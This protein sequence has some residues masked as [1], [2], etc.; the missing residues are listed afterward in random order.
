MKE[1][2]CREAIN[3]FTEK[4]IFITIEFA[5]YGYF[6]YQNNAKKGEEFYANVW[7]QI[8]SKL[9]FKKVGANFEFYLSYDGIEYMKRLQN[10]FVI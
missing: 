7:R 4:K 9:Y 2:T 1:F 10:F 6:K 8:W 3:N 5:F